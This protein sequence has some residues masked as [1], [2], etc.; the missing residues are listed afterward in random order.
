MTAVWDQASLPTCFTST[1]IESEWDA[2]VWCMW[3]WLELLETRTLLIALYSYFPIFLD[4]LSFHHNS[5]TKMQINHRKQCMSCIIQA[6]NTSNK[7]VYQDGY[8]IIN[9]KAI[10]LPIRQKNQSVTLQFET[11]TEHFGHT[12]KEWMRPWWDETC[13]SLKRFTNS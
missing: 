6:C 7:A 13:S 11:A 9:T 5:L 10:L 4:G 8:V 2:A 1:H 3:I 12:Q